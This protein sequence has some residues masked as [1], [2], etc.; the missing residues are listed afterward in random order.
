MPGFIDDLLNATAPEAEAQSVPTEDAVMEPIPAPTGNGGNARASLYGDEFMK[1][2]G[3][4][5]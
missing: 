4:R 3:G 5:E 1:R 2:Y